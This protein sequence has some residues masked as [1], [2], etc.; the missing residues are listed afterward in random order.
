MQTTAAVRQQPNWFLIGLVAVIAAFLFF[1]PFLAVICLAAVLASI[2]LPFYKWLLKRFSKRVAATL[3]MLS[4]IAIVVIPAIFV[5]VASIAQGISLAG[6]LAD[7]DV[8][9]GSELHTLGHPVADAINW[10]FAP[11]TG[12]QPV[13]SATDLHAIIKQIIPTIIQGFIGTITGFLASLPTIM[14]S[15][16]LYGFLFNTFLMYSSSIQRVFQ[17]LSPFEQDTSDLYLDRASTIITASLRTQFFIAFITAV[18]CSLLIIPLGLGG[19]FIFFVIVFTLLGMVPLGSGIL[20]IPFCVI[21]MFV[22]QFW[23]AFWVLI[24]YLGVVCNIDS[25]LRV[26]LIPKNAKLLPAVTTLSTFCGLAYFGILGVIYGPLIAILLTTTLDLYMT[27]RERNRPL[28]PV[29]VTIP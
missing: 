15:A 27:Y 22:G 29:K 25:F 6:S 12:G 9:P 28:T 13:V 1:L 19:Y 7:L 20:M 8:K 3:T 23:P 14:T 4:S 2:F 21:S 24:V 5:F 10:L 26:K 17:T 18:L 16:I 11:F